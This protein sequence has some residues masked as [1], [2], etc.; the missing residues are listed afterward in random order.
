MSE[1][2][3]SCNKVCM[4]ASNFELVHGFEHQLHLLQQKK[5]ERVSLENGRTQNRTSQDLGGGSVRTS[6]I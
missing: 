5:K 6:Q 4:T 3:P 1:K 2:I